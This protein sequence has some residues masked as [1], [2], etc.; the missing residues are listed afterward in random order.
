MAKRGKIP[1]FKF[2]KVWRVDNKKLE[3]MIER[4]LNGK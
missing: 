2:G 1:A 4:K 3:R